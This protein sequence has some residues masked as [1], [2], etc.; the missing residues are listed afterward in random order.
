[1]TMKNNLRLIMA[2]HKISSITELMERTN[3]SRNALNK[4][5]HDEDLDTVKV[6]TLLKICDAFQISLSELL[7][8]TP[9]KQDE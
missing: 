9:E 5:W 4:L 3:L 6:G 1:M 8:Y 7:D 2:Q